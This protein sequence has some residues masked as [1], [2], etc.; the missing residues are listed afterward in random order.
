MA[1]VAELA[2]ARAEQRNGAGKVP[3][4]PGKQTEVML[5]PRDAPRDA[6]PF[7]A[8]GRPAVPCCSLVPLAA[9]VGDVS[10]ES[11]SF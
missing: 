8:L 4:V 9:G 7:E 3:A 1:Q 6:E 2:Q 10:T 11:P 5:R